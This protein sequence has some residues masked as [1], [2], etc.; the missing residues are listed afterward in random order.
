MY[1]PTLKAQRG[2]FLMFNSPC[3]SFIF[4]MFQNEGILEYVC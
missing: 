4:I 2:Q 3:F 1:S